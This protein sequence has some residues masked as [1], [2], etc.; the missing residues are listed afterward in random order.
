MVIKE[1]HE[2]RRDK[3]SISMVLLTPLFQ[4]IILGYAIN[5]DPHNLPTALLNYDTERMSQIFVTE[6]QNTGYFSMIP[7][8][9]EEAAQKAFVR[10]DV[11]FIVTIPEGFTRKLLRGEKPQLLIQGDAIDPITTG[12]ALSALV[13][14]AKSMFQHDLPGDMRV[15]QKEDDFELIIHR[16]F[17][18]EGITQFNT[19]PGIPK[20]S[21]YDAKIT[22]IKNETA[23]KTLSHTTLFPINCFFFSKRR[24][25]FISSIKI[26]I[27]THSFQ[28]ATL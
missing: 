13:Q 4:L 19:I 3:V 22:D 10:G 24:F 18:P 25:N 15:V 16:M 14:V 17:N 9:S 8:D 11:T 5:M 7:V 12:N 23:E 27:R 21:L 1:I 26:F 20:K 28:T 2:L 6:A